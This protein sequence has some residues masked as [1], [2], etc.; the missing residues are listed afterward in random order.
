MIK[1]LI[2]DLDGVI[3]DTAHYHYLSWREISRD[4]NIDFTVK[5]NEN[6]KGVSRID[7]LNYILKLGS[8]SFNTEE[9]N[10][11]L[12]KKNNIY[13]HSIS[14]LGKKNILKGVEK[15]LSKAK[16]KKMLLAVGS[17]SK[18]AKMIV[19]KLN[20]THLFQAVV[21]GTMVK[22]TKPDPEVFL[23]AA[24]KMNLKS[25]ECIVFEDAESGVIAAKKGGFNVV[26]VG[27]INIRNIGDVYVESLEDFNLD[28]YAKYF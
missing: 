8:L 24:K 12:D 7:S 22:K 26:S 23:K 28:Y 6:L 5:D 11:L 2:F 27:N 16:E 21:D 19:E 15:I 4:L 9:K 14:T 18:N 3:V 17:S 13:K 10:N 25:S 20:L 1:G